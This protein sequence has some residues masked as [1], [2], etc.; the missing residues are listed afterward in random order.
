MKIG[1]LTITGR[2]PMEWDG[3]PLGYTNRCRRV[4]QWRDDGFVRKGK[5]YKTGDAARL[6]EVLG[7][8]DATY[9][10]T[11]SAEI[12]RAHI[13]L[14]ASAQGI[15]PVQALE[16]VLGG[17]PKDEKDDGFESNLRQWRAPEQG[18]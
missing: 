14:L 12:R 3:C 9:S 17:W 1:T 5:L 16:D 11:V 4:F 15:K 13:N 8:A 6:I 18:Q 7:V 10:L 2:W